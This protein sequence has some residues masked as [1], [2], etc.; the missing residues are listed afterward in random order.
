MLIDLIILFYFRT[1][2]FGELK[3][4]LNDTQDLKRA[5][6]DR[7]DEQIAAEV[8]EVILDIYI[9]LTIWCF[10][11]IFQ[12]EDE[13]D[14]TY[15]SVAVGCEEPD[16]HIG[17]EEERRSFVI[18]RVLRPKEDEES[19]ESEE[20]RELPTERP[21]DQFVSNPAELRELAEQR[22]N[23][24]RGYRPP[25]PAASQRN[26]VGNPFLHLLNLLFV[27]ICIAFTN[28]FYRWS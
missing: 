8:R 25:G 16:A 28:F 9:Q 12:Y 11:A 10:I 22:R 21:R 2:R 19:E 6:L 15:D 3:E 27:C 17:E 20:E 1:V 5:I 26:V 14:D 7:V 24:R 13:Y 4:V 18:P 23:A